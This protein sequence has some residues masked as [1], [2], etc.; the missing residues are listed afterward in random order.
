ML[1]NDMCMCGRVGTCV[2]THACVQMCVCACVCVLG[3]R[4]DK[5]YAVSYRATKA[6]LHYSP[7]FSLCMIVFHNKSVL[8]FKL[9]S[10]FIVGKSDKHYIARR[11]R[12]ISRVISRVHSRSPLRQEEALYPV[13]FLAQTHNPSLTMKNTSA[14]NQG[15]SDQYSSKPSRSCRNNK[16]RLSN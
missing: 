16:E 1:P 12:S 14:P 11:S 10:N 13:V 3:P 8:F 2:C 4:D 7:C 9:R 6:P 5:Q 15:I